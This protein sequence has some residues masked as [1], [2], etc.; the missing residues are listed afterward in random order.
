MASATNDTEIPSKVDANNVIVGAN[1]GIPTERDTVPPSPLLYLPPELRSQIYDLVI[2]ANLQSPISTFSRR[3]Q[4]LRLPPTFAALLSVNH[5]TRRDAVPLYDA[6]IEVQ[7][8]ERN[9]V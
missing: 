9:A 3:M 7:V 2:T 1:G 6:A 8:F 4:L 5:Q